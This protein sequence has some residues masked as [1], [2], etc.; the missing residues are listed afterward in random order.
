M[1]GLKWC[2]RGKVGGGGGVGGI[3][4][5]GETRT[6]ERPHVTSTS[7]ELAVNA[8]EVGFESIEDAVTY[9]NWASASSPSPLP[10]SWD[11]GGLLGRIQPYWKTSLS[12][13]Q[14]DLDREAERRR[15]ARRSL[16]LRHV[17]PLSLSFMPSLCRSTWAS[18]MVMLVF[19]VVCAPAVIVESI[20]SSEFF[21]ES[22]V[23][24]QSG[25][26]MCGSL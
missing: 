6:S 5:G 2:R 15:T 25:Y 14:R 16:D 3:G 23:R 12:P 18:F 13:P 26:R 4:I 11:P 17:S 10:D 24:S 7:P 20:K 22:A 19:R 8:S 21:S 1:E 9:H